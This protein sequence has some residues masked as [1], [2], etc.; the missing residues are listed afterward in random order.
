MAHGRVMFCYD[1]SE[2]ARHALHAGAALLSP[3]EALAVVAWQPAP[4]DYGELPY[5]SPPSYE[6]LEVLDHAATGHAQAT[7]EEACATLAEAG[8]RAQPVTVEAVGSVWRTLL[9]LAED[10]DAD[11]V[12]IGSRGRSGI[13]SLVL[14]S[15]SHGLVNHAHRPV[16]VVPPPPEPPDAA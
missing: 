15:V 1:G 3:T 12:V 11:L 5:A 4:R 13:R 7:A 14:G 16:L 10:R 9:D 8:I 2:S 6:E